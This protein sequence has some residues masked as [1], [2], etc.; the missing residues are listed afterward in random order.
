MHESVMAV[1][2]QAWGESV[3]ELSMAGWWCREMVFPSLLWGL[4]MQ[5]GWPTLS[6]TVPSS[7]LHNFVVFE[8]T[9]LRETED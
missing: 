7:A 6:M 8:E 9:Q 3:P 5:L 1:L 4:F 2:A